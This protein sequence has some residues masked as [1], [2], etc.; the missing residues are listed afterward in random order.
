MR[1]LAVTVFVLI[2][3]ILAGNTPAMAQQVEGNKETVEIGLSTDTIA[4]TSG[5]RG[6]DLT[7][8]GAL[9]NA[10][11]LIQRQGR[12][13]IVVI[14]QGPERSFVVRRKDRYFGIWI[15]SESVNFQNIPASYSLAS[16]RP[17]QDIAVPKT[18]AQL[19]LGVNNIFYEP[20]PDGFNSSASL[21]EFTKEL[22]RL[23]LKQNLYSQRPGEVQF[24]SSTLFR[25]TLSLPANV[26]VGKHI[27]RA[28]L[29]RNGE[30]LRQSSTS[31]NIVKAGLEYR[32]Y[33]AAH[34]NSLLYGLFAVFL[35]VV[36][37][38]MGRLMF[39]KD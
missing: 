18:F 35:A 13:D 38:W 23:K 24:L 31:L 25:A 10:D 15:N 32:I 29:F 2:A 39:R 8:F 1:T 19:A 4:I 14:L 11:P 21:R 28:F 9:D 30:F 16:T 12:Y 34:E 20:M 37:G 33:K 22:P 6:T 17:L 26:P 36:T 3:V 5:F 27:A 7:V